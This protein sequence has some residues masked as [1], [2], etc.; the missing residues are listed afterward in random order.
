MITRM[1]HTLCLLTCFLGALSAASSRVYAQPQSF[2]NSLGIEFVLIPSGSFMM[3]STEGPANEM[4]RRRITISMPFYMSKY[5]VTQQQWI[6]MMGSN[7][8]PF[9]GEHKPAT[10]MSWNDAQEFVT[11][12]NKMEGTETYRLPTEAEWEYAATGGKD[13]K[14]FWGNNSNKLR[15]YAWYDDNSGGESHDVGQLKPSPWGLYDILGNVGEFT[16]DW[17]DTNYY[18]TGPNVDPSGPSRSS[19]S[20]PSRVR[21]GGGWSDSAADVRLTARAYSY[22]EMI[23][24]FHGLRL[25]KAPY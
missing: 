24:T 9:K 25:V 21:R 20:C 4:P 7:P 13:T 3:G 5:E 2:T 12:L 22:V 1:L 17:Y 23:Q 14:Y 19:N 18:A 8:S 16:A 11:R 6:V 15:Q 10:N